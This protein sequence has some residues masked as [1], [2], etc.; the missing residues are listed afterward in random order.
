VLLRFL[1]HVIKLS[2]LKSERQA[3]QNLKFL[4]VFLFSSVIVA[5]LDRD[6]DPAEQNQCGSMRIRIRNIGFFLIDQVRAFFAFLITCYRVFLKHVIKRKLER[7]LTKAHVFDH[8]TTTQTMHLEDK[9][10]HNNHA[11]LGVPTTWMLCTYLTLRRF[12][13]ISVQIGNSN[14]QY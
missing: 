9:F 10:V 14:F 1:I 2:F 6:P 12:C 7:M 3:L 5:L 13:N 8:H 4:P 11:S